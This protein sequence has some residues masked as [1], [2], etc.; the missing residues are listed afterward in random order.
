MS[1]AAGKCQLRTNNSCLNPEA[2]SKA[3][4]RIWTFRL[5]GRTGTSDQD[6]F[7]HFSGRQQK[8]LGLDSAAFNATPPKPVSEITQWCDDPLCAGGAECGGDEGRTGAACG[9]NSESII[10]PAGFPADRFARC[11]GSKGRPGCCAIAG[12]FCSSGSFSGGAGVFATNAA[13]LAGGPLATFACGGRLTVATGGVRASFV[14]VL[15]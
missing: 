13:R 9:G 11:C 3:V 15:G 2:Y 8:H 10:G 4:R 6:S 12:A 5:A 14:F 1:V 7:P